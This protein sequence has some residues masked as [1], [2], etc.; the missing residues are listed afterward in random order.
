M[1]LQISHL[2]SFFLSQAEL[3]DRLLR[4]SCI[5]HASEVFF[6]LL[7]HMLRGSYDLPAIKILWN[8]G[9]VLLSFPISAQSTTDSKLLEDLCKTVLFCSTDR[10]IKSQ[11]SDGYRISP[12]VL[13]FLHVLPTLLPVQ[14]LRYDL[15]LSEAD[16]PESVP[17]DTRF[18]HLSL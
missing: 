17:E 18:L 16:F 9:M 3:P 14:I 1:L 15:F 2:V 13:P 11:M 6:L 12:A 5:H 8:D 7:L 10:R 4:N